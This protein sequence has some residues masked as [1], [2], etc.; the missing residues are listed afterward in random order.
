VNHL[1]RVV[2]QKPKIFKMTESDNTELHSVKRVKLSESV[3]TEDDE[4][5]SPDL[6]HYPKPT[7]YA[8]IVANGIVPLATPDKWRHSMSSI[9]NRGASLLRVTIVG[10]EFPGRCFDC[11]LN[12]KSICF[13]FFGQNTKD[14]DRGVELTPDLKLRLKRIETFAA[15]HA[16]EEN[17]YSL[18]EGEGFERGEELQNQ[19]DALDP[20]E[21]L[22]YATKL[23]P[24]AHFPDPDV[25]FKV[26]SVKRVSK[27]HYLPPVVNLLCQSPYTKYFDEHT[28]DGLLKKQMELNISL[29]KSAVWKWREPASN[30]SDR[31]AALQC[32]KNMPLAKDRRARVAQIMSGL[33]AQWTCKQ[34]GE[35][36][37]PGCRLSGCLDCSRIRAAL[38]RKY[39]EQVRNVI[40][41]R[42]LALFVASKGPFK[43]FVHAD[44]NGEFY[45]DS[46]CRIVRIRVES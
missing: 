21:K 36:C 23:T 37:H 15:Y 6:F 35:K 30:A 29:P 5:E 18:K 10:C 31:V 12:N 25:I 19:W 28:F 8:H 11:K 33:Y 17:F 22:A 43:D 13:C 16:N 41:N 9:L 4:A 46:F 32:V 44:F 39:K 27:Q 3:N 2:V 1:F 14:A 42:V 20:M 38:K 26:K 34:T 7:D 45:E 40:D 24:V